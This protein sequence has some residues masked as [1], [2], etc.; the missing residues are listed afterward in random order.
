M[1]I[2]LRPYQE[3]LV[4]D[5]GYEFG[6]GRR[7]VCAVM[8]CGA[9]KTIVTAWM[10]R[11]TALSGRRA[12]FMV[13]RQELI[14]QTSATFTEMGIRHGLIAA[15]A[16]KEYD[17]P[18]QI[19]SV[20]T[21]VHRLGEV[22]P[23]D[24]LICDE[25]HHIVANSYR[26]IIDHF[27]AICVLG[28]TATPERIGG[29]GLGE[30]FESLVLGPSAAELIAAGNLTP[31]DYY[32]PPS[33]FDPAAA[34]VR[35]GEYVKS[36]LVNQIDDADVIGD[37]VKNYQNLA[38]GK[39]AICYC[40]NRAHSE[41]VAASFRAAGIPAEHV[42]GET[43][44]AARARAVEEFRAGRLQILCNAELLGE[45][46]DVPAMEAVILA[47]PTA[48]LTLYIQQSMR[49]LRPDP[50]QPEKRAVIID[51][52]GNVFR[53]GLPDEAHAWSLETKKKRPRT[54]AIKICPACY[55]ALPSTARA[56]PCGHV[57]MAAAASEE[58]KYTEKDGT[59]TKIEEIRRKKQRQEVGMARSV[60][61][62]TAIALQ[63]GY[64]LRWVSRM[65]DMKHL[66]G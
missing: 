52:V 34:H 49:P 42:D 30:V 8:P 24:F 12:I 56:C 45:G 10:A 1:E 60:A 16:A 5:V 39:R 7:R 22:P 44:R 66:R 9:G 48:S 28:V 29:Q 61:D 14:E 37:I 57:F 43:H 20:Q 4:D 17:L 35:F 15:G 31:Y 41:H 19:A 26:K 6:A 54:T 38:A 46:F 47:R 32:A 64:S 27:G 63:R 40:I 51:H 33:K 18:V 2:R 3:Q 62:L 50:A 13:H 23:P 21:L 55:T 58:R 36:D 11:G 53:H 59:L 65:A 25:C